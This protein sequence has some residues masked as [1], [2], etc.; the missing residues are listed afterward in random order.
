MKHFLPLLIAVFVV[1]LGPPVLGETIPVLDQSQ[2]LVDGGSRVYSTRELCQTFTCGID[3]LLVKVSMSFSD[4]SDELAPATISIVGTTDGAPNSDDVLWTQDY[5]NGLAQEWFD[6]DLSAAALLLQAGEVY[7]IC[8]QSPDVVYGD[9]DDVWDTN[10]GGKGDAYA[11]GQLWENRG[12]VW[13]SMSAGGTSYPYA[14]AA[15]KTWMVAVPEPSTIALLI[16]L[17]ASI[18]VSKK[19]FL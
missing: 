11:G 12:D 1:G 3:G 8:L 6:V 10:Y 17:S 13:Q 5:P 16:V 4:L 2:I 18:L 9:P 14:D 15:F 7:G 19:H